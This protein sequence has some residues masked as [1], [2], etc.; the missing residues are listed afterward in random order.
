MVNSTHF[1]T[2]D[3][4][5]R[6][7]HRYGSY[8]ERE[9]YRYDA[10]GRRIWRRLVRPDTYCEFMDKASGCLSVVERT[11][12]D[13]DQMLAEVRTDGGTS[14]TGPAMEC[15][16]SCGSRAQL[17][18]RVL[19][20]QGGALDHPLAVLRLDAYNDEIVPVYNWRGR[21][22]DGICVN[23]TSFC[24]PDFAWP[25]RAQNAQMDDPPVTDPVYGG[26]VAWGGSLLDTEKDGSGLVYKRNR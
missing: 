24:A 8:E 14:A 25:A 15:E 17:E 20:V 19:Y 9:E 23:G 4:W 1:D 18:G 3:S 22:V 11:V 16:L 6:Q 21:A 13:G 2:L 12:W 10:L 26:P 7:P 5:T